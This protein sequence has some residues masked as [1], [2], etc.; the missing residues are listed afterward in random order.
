M[1]RIQAIKALNLQST[2][3]I[4]SCEVL[5]HPNF[6]QKITGIDPFEKPSEALIKASSILRIDWLIDIP[7][8][9]TK[10]ENGQTTKI[11]SD[12]RKVTEWGFTGSEWEDESV[13]Q[14]IEEV[15]AYR[16]LEDTIGKV[17]V[18]SKKYREERITST[19]ESR[20]LA[21]DTTLITGLYY[22][23][24]F[25]F[26]IMSFGW[27]KFLEAAAVDP[28]TF[29]VILD[30]FA[31]ISVE[32]VTEWVDDDFPVFF[33][34]DDLAMTNGLVF[35]PEWYRKEIFP[36]YE[37]ILEPAKKAGKIIIFVSDGNYMKLIDDLF[38]LGINGIM[39]DSN[40]DLNWML[41]KYGKK[42]S[43][44]GNINTLILTNGTYKDIKREV[45]R[46]AMIGK[47]YPGYFFKAAG[48]LPHNIPLENIESYFKLKTELGIRF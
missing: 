35:R 28:E 47:K 24:L 48:D 19:R 20:L 16:P 44:I 32:N 45:N 15:L 37:R 18:V 26:C 33:L 2:D 14:D 39:I 23:T 34:H 4:P 7:K 38:S 27:E 46:C 1:G 22:T 43:I 3:Y 8:S 42:H 36:R 30:Q 17:R 5:E 40:N 6:I 29:S 13:F 41:E 21:K 11:S 9:A 12:G 10:F 25:Q 31:E